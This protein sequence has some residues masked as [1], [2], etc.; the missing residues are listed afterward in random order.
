VVWRAYLFSFFPLCDL[1]LPDPFNA[2]HIRIP[3]E[4]SSALFFPQYP[5]FF[6]PV[7]AKKFTSGW[8]LQVPTTG[9]RA[10]I[11]AVEQPLIYLFRIIQLTNRTDARYYAQLCTTNKSDAKAGNTKDYLVYSS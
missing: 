1:S 11:F 3:N 7:P 8:L 5:Q 6:A 10:L 4:S 9:R 2:C